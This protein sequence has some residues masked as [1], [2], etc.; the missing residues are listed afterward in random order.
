[1]IS[2]WLHHLAILKDEFWILLL[3]YI[4]HVFIWQK[5]SAFDLPGK[6]FLFCFV[7]L[8]IILMLHFK[9]QIK[10]DI[11]V[12]STNIGTLDKYEQRQLWK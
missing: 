7:C 2:R 11:T 4:C 9:I 6:T 8:F 12:P 3:L 1:M 10:L 5:Y